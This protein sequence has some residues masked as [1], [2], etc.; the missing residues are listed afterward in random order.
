MELKSTLWLGYYL[1]SISLPIRCP[2]QK[3]AKLRE[4][5]LQVQRGR[6]NPEV[7]PLSLPLPLPLLILSLSLSLLFLLLL[8]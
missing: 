1:S 7:R 6:E 8:L 3:V 2:S 5:K 4:A